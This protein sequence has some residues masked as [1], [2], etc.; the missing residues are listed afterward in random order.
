VSKT[1]IVVDSGSTKADWVVFSADGNQKYNTQG[2]NPYFHSED[3]IVCVLRESKDLL[4]ISDRVDEINFYGAGCSSPELNKIIQKALE[5]IFTR[6]H[7]HVDHDLTASAL[8]CFRGEPEIA[9]I[10]GT[11]SNSCFYDGSNMYQSVPALGYILGDEGSGSFFGKALLRDFLY[12]RLPEAVEEELTQSGLDHKAI[13]ENVYQRP[14]ANVYIAS[15][16][17]ILIRHKDLPYFQ[18]LIGEGLQLFL[19]NHVMRYDN[20]KDVEV[21]F[22]GS[23]A[24]LLKDELEKVCNQ[25]GIRIGRIL[26]RPIEALVQYHKDHSVITK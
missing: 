9:C 19:E 1:F 12:H 17:P 7:V 21:N 10:L 5:R 24:F 4:A 14:N 3:E 13:V 15:F 26:R 16:M 2:F 18:K 23:L 22:V 11:G 25:R 20:Y 6:A 8:A